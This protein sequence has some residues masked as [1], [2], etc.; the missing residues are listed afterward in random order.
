MTKIDLLQ[1][2]E[3]DLRAM[4]ETLFRQWFI[5]E[6]KEDWEELSVSDIAIHVKE[7]VNPSKDPSRPFITF[8]LPAFDSGQK[9]TSELGS[10][11][12]AT[13]TEFPRIEFLCHS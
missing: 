6:A 9:P 5:E 12:L 8:S 10:E 4:A 13:N 2:S 7:N 1:S 11:F 3:Q